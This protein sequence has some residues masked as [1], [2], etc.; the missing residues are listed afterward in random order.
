MVQS[1][2]FMAGWAEGWMA[3]SKAMAAAIG[4]LPGPPSASLDLA[5]AGDKPLRRRG[6]P[7]KA[8]SI[9]ASAAKRPRGR[10]RKN[11]PT[12]PGA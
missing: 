5:A 10:P 8:A 1:K 7:P 9:G 3:A 6:R 12:R 11:D 2:E 4:Q